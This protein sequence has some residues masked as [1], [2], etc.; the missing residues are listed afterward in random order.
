MGQTKEIAIILAKR[1]KQKYSAI[2]HR[3]ALN[4]YHDFKFDS[5]PGHP[6]YGETVCP[7]LQLI[8]DL[9]AFPELEDICNNVIDGD[10]D[11]SPDAEDEVY[12]RTMLMNENADDFLFKMLGLPIPTAKEWIDFKT[13][14]LNN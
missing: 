2:I 10:Y 8:E 4:G 6:E 11:E 5:I 9:S 13:K 3:A 12:I 1:D 14:T 7:K